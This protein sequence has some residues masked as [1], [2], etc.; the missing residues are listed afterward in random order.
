MKRIVQICLLALL[1]SSC[2]MNGGQGYSES[3][4]SVYFWKTEFELNTYEEI[5]LY[6]HD[7]E[8][9][10][11]KLFDV[12]LRKDVD[13]NHVEI[14]PVAT[15]RF[16]DECRYGCEFVPTVF[17]TLEALKEMKGEEILYAEKVVKRILAMA[18]YNELG[19]I[20][21][22]QLD[23]DWTAGTFESYEKFCHFV[24]EYLHA[25][26]IELSITVRLHQVDD[27]KF[28]PADRGVLMLYNTGAFKSIETRNSILDDE[29]AKPYLK[30]IR[31]PFPLDFAYPSFQWSLLFRNE[32]FVCILTETDYSDEDS[33][34]KIDGNRYE[35]LKNTTVKGVDVLKG[36][37]IRLEASEMDQI[38]Q[39][40][41]KI[42]SIYDVS[43]SR[44]I[45][46]HLDSL[47][48][49]KFT[50]DE[51]SEIYRAE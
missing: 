43:D 16:M 5:F 45:L 11:I 22:V 30:K 46:Y 51:I 6:Q 35:A 2:R 29:D 7:V 28:P 15:T 25:K 37:I 40:K 44:T 36:D 38:L 34:R 12:A 24:R 31:T 1:I 17:F 18:S 9:I 8:R 33:F 47:N 41:K 32:E 3:K 42:S 4:H 50:E 26:D 14:V 10:Y 49:S 20:H 19:K 39:V 21:E 23:C 27:R 13:L 48:L